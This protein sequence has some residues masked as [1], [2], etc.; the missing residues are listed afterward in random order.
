[1]SN[2]ILIYVQVSNFIQTQ[3]NE[4]GKVGRWVE[5]CQRGGGLVDE[6]GGVQ[7]GWW[8]RV[9]GTGGVEGVGGG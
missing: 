3:S 6:A 9:S 5:T 1:M 8:W 7:V 2:F 4:G